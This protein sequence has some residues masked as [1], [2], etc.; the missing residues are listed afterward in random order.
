MNEAVSPIYC[1][2]PN[3]WIQKEYLEMAQSILKN[4]CEAICE[5]HLTPEEYI[6]AA[7]MIEQTLKFIMESKFSEFHASQSTHHKN[8]AHSDS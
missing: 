8:H 7:E 3:E 6:V 2:E 4:S 1:D 5:E